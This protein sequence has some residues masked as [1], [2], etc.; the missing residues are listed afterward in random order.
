MCDRVLSVPR[1]PSDRNIL[2]RNTILGR[3]YKEIHMRFV[4]KL[5]TL[6]DILY[7]TIII[8]Y[9][10]LLFFGFHNKNSGWAQNPYTILVLKSRVCDDARAQVFGTLS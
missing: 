3:V 6:Y 4:Y 9:T 7:V 5:Y 10:T 1:S 2:H 8:E